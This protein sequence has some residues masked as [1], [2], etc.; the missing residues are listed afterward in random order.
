[1]G[2][3]LLRSGSSEEAVSFLETTSQY[4]L[5]RYGLGSCM[6]AESHHH[7][8]TAYYIAGSNRQALDAEKIAYQSWKVSTES[9]TDERLRD[10]EAWLKVF[11][12][13]AVKEVCM[14]GFV[15]STASN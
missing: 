8:A 10:S 1:M 7:L 6:T 5:E 11:T 3:M 14:A 2:L 15:S 9:P 13:N 12:A 4:F